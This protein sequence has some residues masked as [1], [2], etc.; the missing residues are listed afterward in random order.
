M[1]DKTNRGGRPP[2]A[3]GEK[4]TRLSVMLRPIYREA[5]EILS[6]EQRTSISQALENVLSRSLRT[7]KIDNRTLL[8]V[9]QTMVYL[10]TGDSPRSKL[11]RAVAQ[12]FRLPEEQ[13]VADVIGFVKGGYSPENWIEATP[14]MEQQLL[15]DMTEEA[16]TLGTPPKDCAEM[17]IKAVEALSGT[18]AYFNYTDSVGVEFAYDLTEYRSKVG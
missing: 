6:R 5:L 9:A 8:E 12:P 7:H 16:Y 18:S 1:S 11:Y 13:Y 2:R 10:G 15:I 14:E 3:P 17:Y 4:M